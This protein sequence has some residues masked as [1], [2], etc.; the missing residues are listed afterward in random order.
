MNDNKSFYAYV[1]SKQRTKVGVG[2]LKDNLENLV[3]DAA[4]QADML[5]D[6]FSSVFTNENLNRI[7]QATEVFKGT[8]EETLENI[9]I[10]EDL[11]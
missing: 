1:R 7:P 2:S 5:N 9:F 3:T 8:Q 6:Y 11:V 10:N 4:L